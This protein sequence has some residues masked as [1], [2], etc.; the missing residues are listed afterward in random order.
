[1]NS[2]CAPAGV[3]SLCEI[4]VILETAT[5]GARADLTQAFPDHAPRNARFS[6]LSNPL[7]TRSDHRILTPAVNVHGEFAVIGNNS[8]QARR[9]SD[10]L[11]S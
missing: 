6:S 11:I 7:P 2:S 9:S 1:M 10:A 5:T 3:Y 8:V 4:D